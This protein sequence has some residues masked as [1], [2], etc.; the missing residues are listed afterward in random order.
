MYRVEG[1]N[2]KEERE[3][4]EKGIRDVSEIDN[5]VFRYIL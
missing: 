2:E 5:R 1:L 3:A 4:V